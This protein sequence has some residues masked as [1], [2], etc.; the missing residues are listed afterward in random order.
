LLEAAKLNG[1]NPQAYLT[2]GF[3]IIA[4]LPI[5]RIEDAALGIGRALTLISYKSLFRFALPLNFQ[6]KI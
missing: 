4:D 3:D 2:W 1:I 5:N 6:I